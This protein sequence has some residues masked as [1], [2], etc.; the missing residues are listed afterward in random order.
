MAGVAAAGAGRAGA[1]CSTTST[2]SEPPQLAAQRAELLRRPERGGP[3]RDRD[4]A[5]SRR[6]AAR[7]RDEMER[8]ERR[9]RARPGRRQVA[10][11][12]SAPPTACRQRFG[13]ERVVDTPLAEAAIIGAAVGL[14]AAGLVP[15]PELQFLGFGLQAF[16][17]IGHQLAR[18]R[19]RTNGRFHA[20]VT[21]RAPFGGGVRTPELHSDGFEA[22]FAQMP[23]PQDRRA[24]DGGRRQG[25]AARA[26]SATPTRCCSSSRCAGY[27][28]VARRGARRRRTGPARVGPDRPAPATTSPSSPGARW[29]SVALEAAGVLPPSRAST[30]RCSTCA[31]WCPLDVAAI[32]ESVSRTG[33][34]VV[35]QE[36]PLTAGFAVRGRGHDP[37]G[38]VP[39]SSRRRS[40]GCRAGT[41]PTRC[42]SSR[43]TTSRPSTGWSPPSAA[44]WSTDADAW[45]GR[46]R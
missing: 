17:Q 8:D 13:A 30:P 27:R 36:A 41:C 1:R 40:P 26:R 22:N 14:A 37:G 45:T 44:P 2:P 46:D 5:W 29:R 12:S 23:G 39:Q 31:R 33:R 7:S 20:P 4:D 28:L 19:Y 34:A 32:A 21:I 42:R 9:H 16:H 25:H 3:A 6:S 15:V 35:V 11:A 43:T 18:W 10:A 38:G 24:G